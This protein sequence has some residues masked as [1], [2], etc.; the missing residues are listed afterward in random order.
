MVKEYKKVRIVCPK[1]KYTYED[2]YEGKFTTTK[3]PDCMTVFGIDK[4]GKP[5]RAGG[6]FYKRYADVQ[7]FGTD[8]LTGQP[9]A[10]DTKGRR[11]D[12][13]DT[14]YDLKRDPHG[15]QKTGKKV[16]GYERR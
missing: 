12:P 11:I 13:A 8:K 6:I 3:C 14:R 9:V 4:N 5:S 2:S 1:C 10:I 16:K 7:A 15:W